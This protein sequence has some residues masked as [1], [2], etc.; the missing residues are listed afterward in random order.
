MADF[1]YIENPAQFLL[2]S[3]FLFEI[4]RWVLHP[5]GLALAVSMSTENAARLEAGEEVDPTE[6]GIKIW[7]NREDS[8]GILFADET[9]AE[10]VE[11]FKKYVEA[12]KHKIEQ[13]AEKLGYVIQ[14]EVG[15]D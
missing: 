5:Y 15:D 2:D 12:N 8:E 6:L 13:R 11:K 1:K 4:N 14:E 7:D 10:G 9:F 3:G